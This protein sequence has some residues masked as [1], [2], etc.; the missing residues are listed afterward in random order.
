ME[1]VLP[2]N[3]V[4]CLMISLILSIVIMALL[5]KFK[6]LPFIKKCWQIWVLNL[7][8]SFLIGVPFAISFYNTSVKDSVWVGLFC[9]IGAPSIYQAL[10]KQNLLQYRPESLK[11]D[12]VE[13]PIEN[14]IT[15]PSVS[16]QEEK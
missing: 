9:F 14:K 10:K 12:V 13:V 5:Q 15:I 8:F 1:N 2:S 11:D 3:F 16:N 6:K 4:N 7:I